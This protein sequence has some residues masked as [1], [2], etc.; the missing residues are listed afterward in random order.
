[1]NLK[2]QCLACSTEMTSTTKTQ[3]CGCSNMTQVQNDVV[4]AKDLSMVKLLEKKYES[5]EDLFY[6]EEEE[7]KRRMRDW[8]MERSMREITKFDYESITYDGVEVLKFS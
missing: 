1:M 7:A 5:H 4:S 6:R 8:Q 3:T 2:V